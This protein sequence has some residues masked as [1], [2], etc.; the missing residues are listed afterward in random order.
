MVKN[1][2]APLGA[3]KLRPLNA[4]VRIQVE[5]D[6]DKQPVRVQR[7]GWRTSRAIA[8]IQDRWR[9]D[10]EWWRTRPISRLYY[11]LLLEDG[12]PLTV[13]HNLI[14]ETWYEQRSQPPSTPNGAP[15]SAKAATPPSTHVWH[16]RPPETRRR[17]QRKT[18]SH[19]DRQA[20]EEVASRR[21]E[22]CRDSA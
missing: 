1:P 15:S 2:R 21:S 9:I 7:R 17:G 12:L 4:P 10:D 6:A 20:S 3:R 11:A 8:R 19:S 13:F 5:I 14:T 22:D 18:P 16:L